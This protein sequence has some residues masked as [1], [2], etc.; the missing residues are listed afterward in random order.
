[1]SVS[2]E[3]FTRQTLLDVRPLTPN[4]FTLRASRDAGYRFRAGQFAR[5]GVTR[6]DGS[7]VWRAYSMVSSPHDEFLEFFS[8]VVPGGEFTSELSR[9]GVG[10]TLLVDRQ[11]FGYLTLDRFVDGRDL[12]M[13]S[14][15]TGIAPFL[16]ILQDF[17]VWEKFERIIL[18]YSVRESSELAYQELIAGLAQREYLAEFAHKLQLINTVTREQHQGA[19]NGRI[20]SLIE[21]GELERAAGVALTPEHSRV[22]LCGNPQMID[23]TRKLLKQRDMQ[24]S[25]SR[26]PGQVAVENFW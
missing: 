21:N 15:G 7:T 8:I 20:T 26:R 6:A 5:L 9:L 18:V 1:M 4:L 22:M 12:W 14:T 11:A 10:D 13:L 17:E 3:K 19:L 16:S 25:L 2:E 23:D 24:L